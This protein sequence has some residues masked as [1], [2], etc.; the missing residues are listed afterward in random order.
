MP[1]KPQTKNVKE[2]KVS[3]TKKM[4]KNTETATPPQ[5]DE[6]LQHLREMEERMTSKLEAAVENATT[7]IQLLISNLTSR[8]EALEKKNQLQERTIEQ[9]RD[10]TTR[11][12]EKLCELER[13]TEEL[14]IKQA[15]IED[16]NRRCN[17]RFRNFPEKAEEK[18]PADLIVSW[19][20]DTIPN[21]TLEV[22]DLERAH[23]A[24]K[25]L[26]KPGAH[27]RDIIVCF[28]RYRKKEEIWNSLKNSTNLQYKN[29]SILVLQ[30]LSQDT[31]NR[32]KNLRPYTQLL[33]QKGIRYRWGFPFR[34]IVTT[35]TTQYMATNE[36]EAQQLLRNLGLD[37]PSNQQQKDLPSDSRDQESGITVNEWMEVKR[38]KRQQKQYIKTR[39]FNHLPSRTKSFYRTFS[40]G[41]LTTINRT[42]TSL[43]NNPT[44]TTTTT[45]AK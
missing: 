26:P 25:P 18:S 41:R 2:M 22:S 34:L 13:E 4:T 7:P 27:P 20:K 28:S 5:N 19:L 15:D 36:T 45:T 30:D 8:V 12:N 35:D 21:L 40:T 16:R 3:P 24:L 1:N 39:R 38:G 9:Y 44:T 37:P 43:R 6:I 23:R 14:R 31:L 32:R 29:N 17:I 33:Q 10:E 11:M 42:K